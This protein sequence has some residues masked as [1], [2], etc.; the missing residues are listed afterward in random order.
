MARG[1][2]SINGVSLV[3]P[4]GQRIGK[5]V[6]DYRAERTVAAIRKALGE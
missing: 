1:K 4:E 5:K 6:I 3:P 2:M